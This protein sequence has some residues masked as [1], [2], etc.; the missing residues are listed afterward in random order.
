MQRMEHDSSCFAFLCSITHND[1]AT[2]LRKAL[3]TA[4][5][6]GKLMVGEYLASTAAL[7]IG[8]IVFMHKEVRK[9]TQPSNR[10]IAHVSSPPY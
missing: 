10:I 6:F 9:S 3:H 4:T 1:V 8:H 7:K 2:N 5:L